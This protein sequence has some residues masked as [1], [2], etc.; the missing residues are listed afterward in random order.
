M[1]VRVLIKPFINLRSHLCVFS[2]VLFESLVHI[3]F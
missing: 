3:R 1:F 2:R